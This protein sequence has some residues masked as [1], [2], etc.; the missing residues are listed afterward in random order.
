MAGPFLA[1]IIYEV[2]VGAR[3]LQHISCG[4]TV[5]S[6]W[7]VKV[8]TAVSSIAV[9]VSATSF[10]SAVAVVLSTFFWE[11]GSYQ[12]RVIVPFISPVFSLASPSI[13]ESSFVLII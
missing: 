10:V 11:A 3:S 5:P 7:K 12:L 8:W 1:I 4:G 13:V 6:W 9:A 2:M